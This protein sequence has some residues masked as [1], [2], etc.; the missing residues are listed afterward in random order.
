MELPSTSQPPPSTTGTGDEAKNIERRTLHGLAWTATSAVGQQAMQFGFTAVLAHLV[1]PADFGLIAMIA[2]LTGFAALFV[3]LGLGPAIVQLP[4]I[5][6]RHLSSA[7]WANL[8]AGTVAMFAV[9]A[10]A[11]AVA[12]FYGEPQL[13][14]LI[15]VGAPVFLFSSLSGVQTALLRRAMNFRRLVVLESVAFAAGNFVAIGMAVSGL[16]AWSFIGLALTTSVLTATLLWVTSGWYPQLR[17]DRRS[18]RELWHFGS[19]LTGFNV[20]N[21]WSRNA[22]NL[23][24]GRFLGPIDL[25]FYNRAYNLMLAP[26]TLVSSTGSGPMFSALSRTQGEKEQTRRMYLRSVRWVSVVSFPCVVMLFLLAEPLIAAVFGQEWLATVPIL[27]ILCICSLLQCLFQV[28]GWVFAS[29]GRTDLMFRLGIVWTVGVVVAFV[30]GLN[31]GV[32]GVATSYACCNILIAIP[33]FFFSGRLIGL[34]PTDAVGAFIGAGAASIVMGGAVWVVEWRLDS[35]VGAPLQLI[36]GVLTGIGT[37]LLALSLISP[38]A[39]RELRRLRARD[40]G[41]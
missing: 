21:Y 39:Y 24:I 18:L 41:D 8:A 11:P 9:M 25:A 27:R 22:D 37:Y 6:E 29:Q 1:A 30:I 19:H 28:N 33:S 36:G 2:V 5:E 32:N 14:A 20:V 13:F 40:V 4:K 10:L 12:R 23:L 35:L 16:G 15:L 31:W 26:V 17:P 38:T 34:S 7:L 3:D